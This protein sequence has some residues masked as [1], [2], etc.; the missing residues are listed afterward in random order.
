MYAYAMTPETPHVQDGRKVGNGL[1]PRTTSTRYV[2]V[3]PT[4]NQ[5]AAYVLEPRCATPPRRESIVPFVR[6]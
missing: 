6:T 4:C 1:T 5:Y 2:D 3:G